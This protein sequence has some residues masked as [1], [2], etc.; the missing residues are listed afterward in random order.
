MY[1]LIIGWRIFLSALT[2]SLLFLTLACETPVAT[3]KL[4]KITFVHLQPF[5]VDVASIEEPLG[6]PAAQIAASILP[7]QSAAACSEDF[8][9]AAREKSSGVTPAASIRTPARTR[10]P[11]PGL[12]KAKRLPP[13][14][15]KSAP[16]PSP[17]GI[18]PAGARAGSRPRA[19]G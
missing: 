14:L 5:S 19:S 6:R 4:P 11:E 8:N 2:L 16:V 13:V 15:R 9:S 7:S 1:F 18:R 12:P 3:Q 17:S 10:V